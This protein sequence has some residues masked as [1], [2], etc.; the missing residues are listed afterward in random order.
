MICPKCRG[1]GAKDGKTKKCPA[2]K[3]Q[4]VRLVKQQMAPG[5]VMQMQQECPKCHGTG[6]VHKHKC[7]FCSGRK[8]KEEAKTLTAT[9]ERGMPS[10]H[11]IV[12]ERESEQSPVRD[13]PRRARCS[14]CMY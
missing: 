5:F 8:V 11:Q 1:T 3:G 10:N 13:M 12:F 14:P 9:I 6:H 2:C 4:G 7:P